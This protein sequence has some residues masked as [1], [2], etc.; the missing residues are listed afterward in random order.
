MSTLSRV[1]LPVR[2]ISGVLFL[3]WAGIHL[4]ISIPLVRLL[5]VVG[6][7]FIIDAIL[8]IITAV[9]LLVGVRVMYIPILVYSWINYL[10]LTES[11]VFPAPVLG[12]PLPTI[13]PV[14]I[15]VIVIDIIIIILV[16][17]TWLGSRRS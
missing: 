5:P 3:V 15:A 2:V 10:L 6:Y 9:L 17:V 7:F 13:N 11:R 4:F 14:I 12:Y 8:A 16:T 1:Y